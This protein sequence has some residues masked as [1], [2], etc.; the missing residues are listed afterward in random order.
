MREGRGRRWEVEGGEGA[1]DGGSWIGA[2]DEEGGSSGLVGFMVVP[3]ERVGV[4]ICENVGSR[5]RVYWIIAGLS[6]R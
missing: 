5:C 4:C 6:R 1:G 3:D 2:E